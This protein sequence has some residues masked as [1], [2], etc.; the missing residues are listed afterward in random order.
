MGPSGSIDPQETCPFG[1]GV[2]SEV[3]GLWRGTPC[4][5][6]LRVFEGR[7]KKDYKTFERFTTKCATDKDFNDEV[8]ALCDLL[9]SKCKELGGPLVAKIRLNWAEEHA[10]VKLMLQKFKKVEIKQPDLYLM[11]LGTYM[12]D[13]AYGNPLENG[14]NHRQIMR[15]G[16]KFMLVR[17]ADGTYARKYARMA[18]SDGIQTTMTQEL[19]DNSLALDNDEMQKL[20][21]DTMQ[22]HAPGI[23]Q[24][25]RGGADAVPLGD[26]QL[27]QNLFMPSAGTGTGSAPLAS[28][29]KETPAAKRQKPTTTTGPKRTS[30]PKLAGAPKKKAKKQNESGDEATADKC[31]T[32][33]AAKKTTKG[34]PKRVFTETILA[35]LQKLE[36]SG[37]TTH[38]GIWGEE[39]DTTLR[40]A[41]RQE[42]D[43]KADM[44]TMTDGAGALTT[45]KY[46]TAQLLLK[47]FQFAKTVVTEYHA[48]EE[49]IIDSPKFGAAMDKHE[50]FLNMPPK[51]KNYLPSWLRADRHRQRI[52]ASRDPL[53]FWENVMADTLA[54]NGF[55]Q[56]QMS[57][58]EFIVNRIVSMTQAQVVI[59]VEGFK[60]LILK[61][62]LSE[63]TPLEI[64]QLDACLC[65][66]TQGKHR[67]T[68][69][70]P[71]PAA[72]VDHTMFDD[73]KFPIC[74]A[75]V[76]YPCGRRAV[77]AFK[78]H[79]DVVEKEAK[80][81]EEFEDKLEMFSDKF[82]KCKS[83]LV[84]A[85]IL[86]ELSEYL[87][88]I[89]VEV[90]VPMAKRRGGE[91]LKFALACLSSLH[92]A[93]VSWMEKFVQPEGTGA[94]DF[95]K[96]DEDNDKDQGP[97]WKNRCAAFAMILNDFK[98][99]SCQIWFQETGQEVLALFQYMHNMMT[100]PSKIRALMTDCGDEKTAAYLQQLLWASTA[101]RPKMAFLNLKQSERLASFHQKILASGLQDKLRTTLCSSVNEHVNV[102][103]DGV[104]GFFSS[105][106]KSIRNLAP[107]G[108][109]DAALNVALQG[110]DKIT[111]SIPV[112]L[113][114]ATKL[115]DVQL[116]AQV[117]LLEVVSKCVASAAHV[118][119][120]IVKLGT[121]KIDPIAMGELA[122]CIVEL[123]AV[124]AIRSGAMRSS[125]VFGA[126]TISKRY[127][128]E[129][130][131]LKQ[132]ERLP[133]GTYNH[134][135]NPNG[136]YQVSQQSKI[137][138]MRKVG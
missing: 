8:S 111:E 51:G 64:Q 52:D 103:K 65:T 37:K 53:T 115:G 112:A 95:V 85:A 72:D 29:G 131:R 49:A 81:L 38:A 48:A 12:A 46:D 33:A 2:R 110:L 134:S 31:E 133:H 138:K 107:G 117:Q 70:V 32:T 59:D 56:N 99:L 86:K 120:M 74:R 71:V 93:W 88:N 47:S 15:H 132:I 105:G 16:E 78:S 129:G 87:L 80:Q 108:D 24:G 18:V 124:V 22:L 4:F 25:P 40:W 61:A 128:N 27:I 26:G 82:S 100:A 9:A 114:A 79:K 104:I 98:V 57:L 121:E 94:A 68:T 30:E 14:Q 44:Q 96:F 116:Q 119:K 91:V 7:F 28:D 42:K 54:H 43:F 118:T 113:K 3:T 84:G 41:K 76:I 17:D 101:Q 5:Y 58:T 89:S 36:N 63:L 13:P 130:I 19:G 55:E 97:K 127:A 106:A 35:W 1:T 136:F 50:K 20:Q 66:L 125:I 45:K 23:V 60:E 137:Y 92:D 69:Y 6:D 34:A 10:K 77:K 123:D 122:K 90:A 75:L 67:I 39:W 11:P 135:P 102:I 83:V 109:E 73:L 21:D 62:P 126:A